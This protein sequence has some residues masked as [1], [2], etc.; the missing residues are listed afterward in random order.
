MAQPTNKYDIPLALAVWLVDDT[1]DFVPSQKSISAT[2]LLKPIRHLILPPRVAQMA[3]G[4]VPP[5][6]LSDFI[7]RRYGH[8]LHDSIE[9]AWTK[10]IDINLKI[11]GYPDKI[12]DKV[13]VNPEQIE[14]QNDPMIIPVYVEQRATKVIDGWTISGKFDM[15]IEGILQDTKSTSA[16]AWAKGTRDEEHI[17]Q[18][19][20]YH[21]LDYGQDF[22]KITEDFC[23]VNYIFTDWQKSMARVNP[24]YP[25][26][27]VESK[28]LKL[29]S[30]EETEAFIRNKIKLIEKYYTTPEYSLPECTDEELW[31]SEP[32]Y[33]YFRDP[34]KASTPGS[35]ATKNFDTL[36]E[37]NA[38]LMGI[39]AGVVIT[40]P[41]EVKRCEYCDA[42]PICTQKDK[43]Q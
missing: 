4:T 9:K 1:Y 33:K 32:V 21:W 11:L 14:V 16:W 30:L 43:Y 8:A 25:Q 17:Q 31:R 12:I 19:S 38:H 13:R 36:A 23:Q 27:R 7:A 24:N 41:G 3:P 28:K 2:S 18:L 20:I 22:S 26:L 34:A 6:D 5:P 29:M 37:A 10:R 40:K 35:R 42:F 15:C 39:G